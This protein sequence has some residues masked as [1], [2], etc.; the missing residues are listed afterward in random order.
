[1]SLLGGVDQQKEERERPRRHRALLYR[2]TV[3]PAHKLLDGRSIGVVVTPRAR[4]DTKLLDD[5]ECFPSLEPLDHPAEC[6][7]EPA[8]IF[9][10]REVF[11]ASLWSRTIALRVDGHL[12]CQRTSAQW[13]KI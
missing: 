2:K 8:D 7:G 4:R 6:G 13:R 12:A 10:E 11:G 1:M 3:D 5:L 9:V